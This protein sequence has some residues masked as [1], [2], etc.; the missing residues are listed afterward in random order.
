MFAYAYLKIERNAIIR[1]N[2]KISI[3]IP[4]FNEAATIIK[5]LEQINNSPIDLEKEIIVIDDG[6]I[7]KTRQLIR[8]YEKNNMKLI[9]HEKNKGKGAAIRTA[10]KYI[11]GDLV[12]IQDADLEYSPRDY[13]KLIEP[14]LSLKADVVFG[15]RFIGAHRCYLFS[16]YIG[17]KI[18]NLVANVLYNTTLTDFMTGYKIFKANKLKDIPILSNRFGFE[19]EITGKVF[20]RGLRVYEVPIDYNGRD[21]KEGKKIKWT[22][23]FV[24]LYWLIYVRLL[25]VSFLS[26]SKSAV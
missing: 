9:F 4:V 13:P 6:S 26:C 20:R 19:A 7:D 2:M 22:D 18:I 17:N 15:S 3:I 21:Y 23:F 11:T 10:M 5:T 12:L 8:G 25:P 14:I 1:E 16:H 24:V